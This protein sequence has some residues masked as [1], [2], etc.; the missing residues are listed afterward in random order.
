MRQEGRGGQR[1]PQHLPRG[2]AKHTRGAKRGVAYDTSYT[3]VTVH[4]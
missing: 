1:W 3:R 4:V 2:G